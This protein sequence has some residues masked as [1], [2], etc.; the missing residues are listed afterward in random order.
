[1]ILFVNNIIIHKD[2]S[3]VNLGKILIN[4]K[5]KLFVNIL[6]DFF[7]FINKYTYSVICKIYN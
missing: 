4:K 6:T 1:M 5:G 7:F 2:T 3:K